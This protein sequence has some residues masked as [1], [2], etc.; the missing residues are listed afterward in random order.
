MNLCPFSVYFDLYYRGDSISLSLRKVEKVG[1]ATYWETLVLQP[2][3]VPST[4]QSSCS[5]LLQLLQLLLASKV[6]KTVYVAVGISP[7]VFKDTCL[8]LSEHC[9]DTLKS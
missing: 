2:Y 5:S 6:P 4:D 1:T 9:S 8:K 3:E 7:H